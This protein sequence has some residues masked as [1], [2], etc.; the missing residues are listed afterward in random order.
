[1]KKLNLGKK[2]LKTKWL[3]VLLITIVLIVFGRVINIKS[4]S[5]SAIVLGIGIDYENSEFV[6][7]T[8]TV[9]VSNTTGAENGGASNYVCSTEKG[10]TIT[11]ALSI[12][13]QRLGLN[14]SLSHCNVLMLSESA[15]KIQHE[16]LIAPLINILSLPEQSLVVTGNLPPKELL[17]QR[18]STTVNAPFFLQQAVIE[19]QGS[20]GIVRTTV[21]DFLAK[22]MSRSASVLLP[23]IE[24]EKL[25]EQPM[26]E[27]GEGEGFVKFVLDKILAANNSSSKLIDK[28][29][30]KILAI[31]DSSKVFGMLTV[32]TSE[33]DCLNFRV[34]DTS[35]D[36]KIEGRT[37]KAEIEITVNYMELQNDAVTDVVNPDTALVQKSADE[38]AKQLTE[39]LEDCERISKETGI[40]F[41]NLENYVYQKIGRDLEKN[42]LDKLNFEPSIKITVSEMMP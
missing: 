30:S 13:G 15:L 24:V 7:T 37:V 2:I 33:G 36:K 19:L 22:S 42:C 14:V 6:V 31:Y 11:Q 28:E 40:D 41:L 4:L 23:Y 18:I 5:Q 1:M 21:K 27:Q 26:N 29:Q 32:E 3:V 8:Q 17:N 25:D 20:D 9:V 16:N 12:I 35:F 39:R 10:K 38:L 34:A